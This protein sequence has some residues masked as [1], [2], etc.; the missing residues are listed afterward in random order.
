MS[1]LNFEKFIE[2]FMLEDFIMEGE[3]IDIT[4]G[5]KLQERT[6]N[7]YKEEFVNIHKRRLAT[8]SIEDSLAVLERLEGMILS[9]TKKIEEYIEQ[10]IEKIYSVKKTIK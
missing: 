7:A 8:L 6:V 1:L 9:R 2:Y 3:P 4:T 10:D 5:E